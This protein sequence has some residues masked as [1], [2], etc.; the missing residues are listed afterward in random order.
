MPFVVNPDRLARKTQDRP[1]LVGRMS[2]S[3]FENSKTVRKSIFAD[4]YF[5][6]TWR[7]FTLIELLVVIAII[8]I[9]AALLLPALAGA[10]KK[11]QAIA[12]LGNMKQW[13]LAFRMYS[14]DNHDYVPEEG[15]VANAINNTGSATTAD[16]LDYGWYNIVAATIGQP[17][18]VSL[19]TSGNAPLPSSSTIFS[20]PSCAMPNTSPLVGYSNPLKMSKVFFMYCENSRL[21]VNFGTI[22]AGA[23]QTKLSNLT[24]PS[25]TVFLGE[26]DPNAVP[27]ADQACSVV[28]AAYAVA[29]H[30]KLGNLA[31]CD[32]SCVGTQTN[33][34]KD[35]STAAL[36]WGDAAHPPIYWWPTP[37]TPQ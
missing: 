12:C 29:R 5:R 2:N 19:Y 36:E 1:D 24:K 26:Q 33:Q 34:F 16:N 30:G 13:G 11:A 27:T 28:T 7:A 17:T 20:C 9:L 21:C 4:F 14:D 10:K 22:A 15:N 25:D 18:L 32:G 31:M 8:A 6:Q 35:Y 37:S 3:M 23:Q